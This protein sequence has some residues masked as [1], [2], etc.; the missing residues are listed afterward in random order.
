MKGD[1]ATVT[2]VLCTQNAFPCLAGNTKATLTPAVNPSTG[3][4]P[5]TSA[6]LGTN[7]N[8]YARAT[9]TDL[10]ANT[11]QSPVAGPIAIP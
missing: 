5:V 3:A 2:V 1:S 9:Q 6:T 8:L 11:G 4:W 10:T 7:L